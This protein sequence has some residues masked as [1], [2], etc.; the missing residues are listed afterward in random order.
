[1]G[2]TMLGYL[3][4]LEK[5]SLSAHRQRARSTQK[6]SHVIQKSMTQSVHTY[7][8]H[9]IGTY[10]EKAFQYLTDQTGDPDLVRV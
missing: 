4:K 9:I 10:A 3:V 7:S 1:M 5:R 6:E 2:N 8:I